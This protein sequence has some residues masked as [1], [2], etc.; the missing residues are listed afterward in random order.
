MPR[1]TLGNDIATLPNFPAEIRAPAGTLAGVSSFQI[2]SRRATSSRRATRRPTLLIAMNPGR[3][4]ANI[5]E[6]R[7]RRRRSCANEDA[8]TTRNLQK[9]GYAANPLDDGSL[10]RFVLRRI[11]DEY[12]EPARRRGNGDVSA[13]D[14]L[15][16]KNLF[17][18]GLLSWLYDRRRR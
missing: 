2:H 11:P 18:L 15:R 7:A 8:F 16:A 5:G 4:E 17:A 9:A 14:A 12:A 1:L 10:E 3:A 13:R 6:P